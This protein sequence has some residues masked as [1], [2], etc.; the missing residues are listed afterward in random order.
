MQDSEATEAHGGPLRVNSRLV[1]STTLTCLAVGALVF[2]AQLAL[3]FG[4]SSNA[5]LGEF[6]EQWLIVGAQAALFIAIGGALCGLL[7][8]ALVRAAVGVLVLVLAIRALGQRYDTG[9]GVCESIASTLSGTIRGDCFS[10]PRDLATRWYC[11]MAI[12]FGI[13]IS[14][15]RT[16]G[17]PCDPTTPS[18][19]P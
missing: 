19:R 18:L 8:R 4:N 5:P 11:V 10:H 15:L 1:G 2:G 6:L 3:S 12:G 17:A 13:V 14:A 7:N 9:D 16:F